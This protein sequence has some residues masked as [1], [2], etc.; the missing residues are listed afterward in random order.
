[1]YDRCPVSCPQALRQALD[2]MRMDA[3]DRDALVGELRARCEAL[4]RDLA[5]VEVQV[6]PRRAE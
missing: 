1:M 5:A 2:S 4:S 3:S 6:R